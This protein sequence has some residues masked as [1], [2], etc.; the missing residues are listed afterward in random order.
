MRRGL[1]VFEKELFRRL[2]PRGSVYNGWA[3]AEPKSWS[4]WDVRGN[5]DK[6]GL[7][8]MI[9]LCTDLLNNHGLGTV[10]YL[11]VSKN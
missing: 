1:G 2:A 9:D 5:H 11:L 4:K 10:G 8:S 6:M 7:Q 3:K